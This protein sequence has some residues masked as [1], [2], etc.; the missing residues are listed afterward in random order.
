VRLGAGD[1]CSLLSGSPGKYVIAK[2][3]VRDPAIVHV[4]VYKESFPS[5]PQQIDTQALSLGSSHDPDGFGMG[6]LPMSEGEFGLWEP[7]V[8]HRE[9]V[10]QDELEGHQIWK[11]SGGGVW[12]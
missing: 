1:V 5:R 7:I 12:A 10:A 3:L 9:P 6:H 8:I 4:R 2:V 11:D